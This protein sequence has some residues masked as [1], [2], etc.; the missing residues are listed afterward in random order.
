MAY[1]RWDYIQSTNQ[2]FSQLMFRDTTQ[3]APVALTPVGGR[4]LQPQWDRRG[5]RLVYVRL[6]NG[7][8]EI[9][10]APLIKTSSG[11]QLGPRRVIASGEV[12]QPSFTPDGKW[13]SYLRVDG[14]GFDVYLEPAGGGAS[15]KLDRIDSDL[16]ARWRPMWLP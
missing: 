4:V 9:A 6:T 15:I 5:S 3:F 7:V 2:P 11:V 1:V 10:V 13:I 16:D 8:D 14:D 12:A